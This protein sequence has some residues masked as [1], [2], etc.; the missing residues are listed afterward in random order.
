MTHAHQTSPTQFVEANGIRFAHRRFGK[1]GGVPVIFNQ[2]FQSTLDH[3]DPAVSDGLTATREVVLFDNAGV[4]SSS[5]EA[6]QTFQE[7]GGDDAV[8]SAA[9]D[10]QRDQPACTH[11]DRITSGL[12]C[13]PLKA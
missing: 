2:H 6:P 11:T 5:G 12:N 7:M 13:R 9:A 1:P 8:A 10:D 3:W 4:A